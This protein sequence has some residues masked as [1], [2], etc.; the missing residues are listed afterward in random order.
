[1]TISIGELQKNISIIKNIKEPII[2]IDKKSK[3]RIA[4]IEPIK[5]N[6][7]DLLDEL[8]QF[9]KKVDK[10]YSKEDF[11]KIYTSSLKAK[12]DIN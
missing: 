12:Y 7:L 9:D 11:E 2:V 5:D 8:M 1:M 4:I 6:D 10:E 3:K